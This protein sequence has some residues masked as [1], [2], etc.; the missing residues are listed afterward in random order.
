MEKN[1][2][3]SIWLSSV[4]IYLILINAII[5]VSVSPNEVTVFNTLG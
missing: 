1:N 4:K 3:E 5:A 2:A